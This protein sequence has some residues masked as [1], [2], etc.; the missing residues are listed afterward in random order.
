MFR[1]VITSSSG[2]I[3]ASRPLFFPSLKPLGDRVL[4][5]KDSPNRE[6]A[7]GIVLPKEEKVVEATVVEVGPGTKDVKITLKAGDRVLLPE[8]GGTKVKIG[9]VEHFLYRE[10]EILGVIVP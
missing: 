5:K 8:W 10:S 9:S 7:S 4:I 1:K 2:L 6:T 3:S